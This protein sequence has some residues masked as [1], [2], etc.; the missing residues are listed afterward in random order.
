MRLHQTVAIG[1][2][3]S[4]SILFLPILGISTKPDIGVRVSTCICVVTLMIMFVPALLNIESFRRWFCWTDALSKEQK[5]AITCRNLTEYYRIAY[6]DG[7]VARLL[8]YLKRLMFLS[9]A[10]M[11]ANVLVG[12]ATK[13][14]PIYAA[15]YPLGVMLFVFTSLPIARMI[16]H[17]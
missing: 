12:E 1:W 6:E 7:Y 3:L 16:K 11:L 9:I 5:A 13:G 10:L 4:S 17:G 8:P 14:A 15:L 2:L